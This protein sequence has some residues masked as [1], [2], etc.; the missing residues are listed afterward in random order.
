M[1]AKRAIY[2][3]IVSIQ[4]A[5]FAPEAEE[6]YMAYNDNPFT[7]PPDLELSVEDAKRSA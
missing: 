5:D 4:R 1:P 7:L 2:R 3:P 6:V